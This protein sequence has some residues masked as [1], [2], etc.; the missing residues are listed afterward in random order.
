[1]MRILRRLKITYQKTYKAK[2]ASLYTVFLTRNK[3][4]KKTNYFNK[5]VLTWTRDG[6]ILSERLT[7]GTAREKRD[8]TPSKAGRKCQLTRRGPAC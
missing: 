7:A 6:G 4:Y 3:I 5:K 8:A 1:M 2:A